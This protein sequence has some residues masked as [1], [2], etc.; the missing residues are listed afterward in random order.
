[1]TVSMK[2]DNGSDI[3]L[4][5]FRVS[6]VV[7]KTLEKRLDTTPLNTDE[8]NKIITALDALMANNSHTITL[9]KDNNLFGTYNNLALLEVTASSSANST[10][11]Y[12]GYNVGFSFE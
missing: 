1:M 4:D 6:Y 12:V 8:W 5:S 10:A 11:D 9:Y 2:I 7:N 3:L